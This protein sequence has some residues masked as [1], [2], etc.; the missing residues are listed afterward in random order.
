MASEGNSV[1]FGDLGTDRFRGAGTNNQIRAM[2][3]LEGDTNQPNGSNINV[4]EIESV[5]N[6]EFW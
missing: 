1:Y 6:I 4:I 5:E 3:R 2:W